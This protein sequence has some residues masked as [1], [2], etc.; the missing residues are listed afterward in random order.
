MRWRVQ[1]KLPALSSDAFTRFGVEEDNAVVLDAIRNYFDEYLPQVVQKHLLSN[2]AP[3]W[4]DEQIAQQL[5]R[6]LHQHGINLRHLGRVFNLV[7]TSV[8]VAAAAASADNDARKAALRS[9]LLREMTVRS[10]KSVVLQKLRSNTAASAEDL[11]QGLA[12]AAVLSALMLKYPEAYLTDSELQFVSNLLIA[13]L[14][15]AAL[16]TLSSTSSSCTS[17]S[18]VPQSST[19]VWSEVQQAVMCTISDVVMAP[20]FPTVE[21]AEHRLNTELELRALTVGNESPALLETMKLLLQLYLVWHAE[22]PLDTFAKAERL[23]DRMVKIA[24]TDET[25][26]SWVYNDCGVFWRQTGHLEAAISLCE[27]SLQINESS[28]GE[29]HPNVLKSLN[30]LGNLYSDRGDYARAEQMYERALRLHEQVLGDGHPAVAASLN[31]LAILYSDQGDYAKAKPLYERALQL[32]EEVLGERHPDVASSLHNL[33]RLYSD[34]GDYAKA[35]PFNERALRLQEEVLGERHPHVATCLNNLALVYCGQEEYA[36]AEPLCQR[37]LR[38]RE[39]VLG[40][41]HPDVADSLDCLANLFEAQ[42]RIDQALPLYLRA[43]QLRE[44]VLGPHHPDVA[45]SCNNLATL[46]VKKG[47]LDQAKELL[48]QALGILTQFLPA[49]HPHIALLRRNLLICS[50]QSSPL[51]P[52]PCARSDGHS[53]SSQHQT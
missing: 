22:S 25:R 5:P 14:N 12:A 34:Q 41:R 18:S 24:D 20:D 32:R 27:R 43:L 10:L 7:S 1:Q 33:A 21:Q 29:R 51:V 44:E 9:L 42:G 36:K 26:Y 2:E 47:Q 30:N 50:K 37:A 39:E 35:Q 48:N 17:P 31:N 28:L 38:L 49:G 19:T 8:V 15:P 40:E 23:V 3:D 11:F 13:T 45:T 52:V 4:R 16:S 53:A 46:Y 6:V